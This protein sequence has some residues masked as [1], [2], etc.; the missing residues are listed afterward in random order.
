[1]PW[2]FFSARAAESTDIDAQESIVDPDNPESYVDLEGEEPSLLR[3]QKA[4]VTYTLRIDTINQVV[5]AY[6]SGGVLKR[7]MIC[8]T[9]TDEDA[10]PLGTFSTGSQYRWG[11]FTKFDCWAQYWTRINGPILFHSV[12]YQKKDEATLIKSSVNN[13]GKRASHGCVRLRV[14]DAKWI[15]DNCPRGTKTIIFEGPRDSKYTAAVKEKGALEGSALYLSSVTQP[16]GKQGVVKSSSLNMRAKGSASSTVVTTLPGGAKL[17]V[18]STSGG[19][20]RVFYQGSV[21][22]VSADYLE[23][24]GET[25]DDKPIDKP[26]QEEVVNYPGTVMTSGSSLN[27]REAPNSGAAVLSSMPNGA[28]L[29]VIGVSDGWLRVEFQGMRGYCS[30]A[31]VKYDA[32]VFDKGVVKTNGGTLNLRAEPNATSA[33]LAE[34]PNG[35]AIQISSYEGEWALIS[36]DGQRGYV[37]MRFVTGA[38]K[39]GQ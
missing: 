4:S 9:G 6:T 26:P 5:S 31:Y 27:L 14:A 28:K 18:L 19:W 29:T 10:T 1:M 11:F 35:T 17:S 25:I 36:Y 15:N 2:A 16:S 39:Y 32:S 7:Q 34:L 37:S 22:Y 24:T 3:A 12:L 8:S 23:M 38:K 21:G 30:N 13:L 33:V 20:S